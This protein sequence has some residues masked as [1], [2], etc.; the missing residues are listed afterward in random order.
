MLFSLTL[1]C[2]ILIL[3]KEW[4]EGWILLKSSRGWGWRIK[5]STYRLSP[6]KAFRS[7]LWIWLWYSVSLVTWNEMHWSHT[8]VRLLWL[9]IA[10]HTLDNPL[11][12]DALNAWILF[13][14]RFRWSRFLRLLMA[15]VG[16]S[17]SSF[18]L[19]TKW[20]NVFPWEESELG[21]KDFTPVTNCDN[22]WR[23]VVTFIK[24]S[25]WIVD[26]KVGDFHAHKDVVIQPGDGAFS[27][28]EISDHMFLALKLITIT[29]EIDF[30]YEFN[31]RDWSQNCHTYMKLNLVDIF[32]CNVQAWTSRA[33]FAIVEVIRA[34]LAIAVS[35]WPAV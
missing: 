7:M 5:D 26:V 12:A 29:L 23:N 20:L 10:V 22:V 3:Y 17:L 21:A 2:L 4:K 16:T 11:K 35:L 34:R 13:S 6:S 14:L 18:L 19:R 27:N 30:P 25:T 33:T 28:L 24:I 8:F 15:R 9:H 31:A 32:T 1:P